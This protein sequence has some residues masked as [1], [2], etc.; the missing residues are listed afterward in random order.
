MD[1]YAA[2]R[3]SSGATQVE[4]DRAYQ[5]LI[6]DAR[7]DTSINRK[8][9]DIAYRVLSDATQRA[10]YDATQAEKAKQSKVSQKILRKDLVLAAASHQ[11]QLTWI[12]V[13]MLMV[14]GLYYPYRFGYKLK[15]F[16]AGDVLYLKD[17]DGYFGKVVKVESSHNFHGQKE[18]AYL[19]KTEGDLDIWFPADDVKTVCYKKQ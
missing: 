13:A 19:V 10:L 5:K 17:T 6:K 2:L 18:D 11:K 9:L 12:L 3:V 8:E 16:S 7:Y 14:L 1:Y 15:S 4:I